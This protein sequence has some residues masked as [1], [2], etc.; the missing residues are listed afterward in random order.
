MISKNETVM[1]THMQSHMF[2][3]ILEQ[4]RVLETFLNEYVK[5][6]EIRIDLPENI[7]KLRIIASGSSYHAASIM[8][9]FFKMNTNLD[10]NCDYSSEFVL[11][12]NF[13]YDE[14]TFYIFI[15]QSG[16]T[17][18]T[19]NAL[20][21]AK[22]RGIST[23]VIT[24]TK[25]STLWRLADYKLFLHAGQEL[26]IASTKSFSA[27]VLAL[28]LIML[29][30]LQMKK[31]VD[32]SGKLEQLQTLPAETKS[33]LQKKDVIETAA[34][35]LSEFEN[36]II[37]G[38]MYYYSLALEGALKIKETSYINVSPFPMGEFLH[39]HVA[40]LNN[41]SAVLALIDDENLKVSLNYLQ[42]ITQEYAPTIITISS[43]D[44]E[45]K[46]DFSFLM[47]KKNEI[48]TIFKIIIFFQLLAYE[49]AKI[50]GKNIDM[51]KGLKKVVLE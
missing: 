7:K 25:D 4:P 3:E 24:N 19:I 29:K 36:I 23:M 47:E 1:R 8:T 39:G 38:N 17:T 44:L 46:F 43:N 20:K 41:K 26:S 15:S 30:Y 21:K 18:D 13:G 51:P 34:K 35:I 40:V 5:D 12:S 42:K 22:L 48:S 32:V 45:D 16:E 31:C 14:S 49:I 9:Y 50:L 27:Q 28:Y 10:V 37:L 11:K 2:N 33:F 6:G